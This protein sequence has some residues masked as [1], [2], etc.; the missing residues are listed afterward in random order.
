MSWDDALGRYL[1]MDNPELL[2]PKCHG[3]NQF[4][5]E[6]QMFNYWLDTKI[7]DRTLELP[8]KMC[9]T[10]A[11]LNTANATMNNATFT[12][13][14]T[15]FSDMSTSNLNHTNDGLLGSGECRGDAP[16]DSTGDCING[17][18]GMNGAF[19][20][21]RWEIHEDYWVDGSIDCSNQN[22]T[23]DVYTGAVYVSQGAALGGRLTLH[24]DATLDKPYT[25]IDV[26]TAPSLLG[27][28]SEVTAITD[29][30]CQKI[31][32]TPKYTDTLVSVFLTYQPYGCQPADGSAGN[33]VTGGQTIEGG[34][35]AG[36]QTLTYILVGSIIGGLAVIAAA[37][38][39][40]A[41]FLKKKRYEDQQKRIH[42]QLSTF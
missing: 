23:I 15:G 20:N 26:L 35:I 13:A 17:F 21:L 7:V 30:P 38:A 36:G 11:A 16:V 25:Q 1:I 29:D 42:H 18:W 4:T 27:T 33:G 19:S 34:I 32:A 10:E 40:T 2:D 24:I 37:V 41:Y 39:L 9:T 3:I 31:T 22:C 14:T 6:N 8:F 5:H 12:D 28:F